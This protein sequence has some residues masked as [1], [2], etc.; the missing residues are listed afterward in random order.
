MQEKE[1]VVHYI[2]T[3]SLFLFAVFLILFPLIFNTQST[4]PIVLPKQALLGTVTLIVFV[5]FAVK[6][7]LEKGIRLRRTYFDIPLLLILAAGLASSILS[8]N[9]FDSL[10]AFVPYLF[11]ILG[12]FLIV[13]TAKNNNS[14]LLLMSSLIIGAV[15]LSISSILSIFQ[16]HLLPNALTHT[17]TFTPLGSLLDQFI[18][19]ITVFPI[20]FYFILRTIKSR[21]HQ[22]ESQGLVISKKYSLNINQ[23]VLNI[24]GIGSFA[25]VIILGL[26]ATSYSLVAIQK[27][28]ILPVEIG[29][30]TAF[31]Q[32]SLDSGRVIQGFLFGSGFGTYAVDF[33]RWKQ[34]SINLNPDLW[35][36]TFFRSSSFALELLATTGILGF[37]AFV[38]LIIRAARDIKKSIDNIMIFSLSGIVVLTIMLP[39]GFS[40]QVLLFMILALFAVNQSLNKHTDDR[41]FDIELELVTLKKGLISLTNPHSASH[42]KSMILP[43][44]VSVSIVILSGVVGYYSYRFVAADLLFQKSLSAESQQNGSLLYNQQARAISIFP[45]RDSFY[46]VFS[47]TN[48][49]IANALA[50]QQS[51]EQN[52]DPAVQQNIT[53]LIQQSINSARTATTVS[54]MTALNWQNLSSIYRSLIGFG[55]NAEGFAIA[56]AQRRINLDPNNPQ[57]Y[58]HLGGIY[59]QLSQWDSAQNQFQI[60]IALKSDLPNAHYNLGHVFEEKGDTER[61]L[62]QYNAVKNLVANNK[63]TLEQ[64]TKEIEVLQGK[65]QKEQET[66]QNSLPLNVNSSESQ[67]PERN[68]PL[69]IPGPDENEEESDSSEDE[70]NE[71]TTPKVSPTTTPAITPDL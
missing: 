24:A 9:R 55:Q 59:Y 1:R 35:N 19:L 29:F 62:A 53:S 37:S 61:A 18:Y 15:I 67:L 5:L 58:I 47:Q 20:A 43:L 11:S 63:E 13:N 56:T 52:Q 2:Q 8:A 31:S 60:A 7:I 45:Y 66:N 50:S 46:R 6:I 32:I 38:F 68:P 28:A 26:I 23:K 17:Q 30:Q 33:T 4:S 44:M 70:N 12:Y 42:K 40:T 69:E 16:I 27:P 51:Q 49:S 48:L 65:A 25:F 21:K 39:L 57:G 54:P 3:F 64:I 22:T 41:Y 71:S 10:I 34:A 36:L 14:L